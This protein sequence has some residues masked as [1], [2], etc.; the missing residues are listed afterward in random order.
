MYSC[1]GVKLLTMYINL[2]I[3]HSMAFMEIDK[4]K[5]MIIVVYI[6]LLLT[7]IVF[8]TVIISIVKSLRLLFVKPIWESYPGTILESNGEMIMV[9]S[10]LFGNIRPSQ[11]FSTSVKV[12]YQI[13]EQPFEVY[14]NEKSFMDNSL[15]ETKTTFK[16]DF[17]A[18]KKIPVYINA[19]DHTEIEIDEKKLKRN[20]LG[21]VSEI[22]Y[23]LIRLI[24]GIAMTGL[25]IWGV[26][27]QLK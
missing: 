27:S 8:L 1:I 21:L 19:K 4:N 3:S 9:H 15:R 17:P 18:G 2:L 5:N 6:V 25:G 23:Y 13:N 7:G 10:R 26:Y 20:K 12:A 24:M 14:F 16:I 11:M 22:L